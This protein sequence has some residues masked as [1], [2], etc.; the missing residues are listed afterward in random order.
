MKKSPLR[1]VLPTLVTL[2]LLVLFMRLGNWQLDR[3]NEKEQLQQKMQRYGAPAQDPLQL[4]TVTMK[5]ASW[6]YRK[7]KLKGQFDV[8]HQYLLDNRMY[9][10]RAGFH[11]LT[12]L[13]AQGK[14][15]LVNRGWIPVGPERNRFP[16]L[17]AS[18]DLISVSGQL[19]PFG[20]Q[21]LLLGDAGFDTGSWPRII[22]QL[23][24][25]KMRRQIRPNLVPAI[26]RLDRKISDCY[27]C[28]WPARGG[29]ISAIRHRAYA[30]Q[31]FALTAALLCLY[32]ILMFRKPPHDEG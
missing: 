5:E 12:P 17:E 15:L 11:V 3:G 32:L 20:E 9:G 1:S 19:M 4:A 22:Q 7:V 23:D 26:L 21:P 31:W 2:T 27:V 24:M 18:T 14:T 25:E 29:A 28:E 8:Q 30:F 16:S 10:G 13:R 6:H